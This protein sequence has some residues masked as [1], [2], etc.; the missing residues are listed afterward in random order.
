MG[1]Y[2]TYRIPYPAEIHL[3]RKEA[4]AKPS[5]RCPK[6]MK[7]RISQSLLQYPRAQHNAQAE[8]KDTAFSY[9]NNTLFIYR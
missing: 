6:E 2:L 8:K 4:Y 1:F 9:S 3:L 7:P 5:G